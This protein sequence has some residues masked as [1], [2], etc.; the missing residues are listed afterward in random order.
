[1]PGTP[2]LLGS[3]VSYMENLGEG[4]QIFWPLHSRPMKNKDKMIPW[5]WSQGFIPEIEGILRTE[6][7]RA[8]YIQDSSKPCVPKMFEKLPGC[9][10]LDT[11][12]EFT[13][14]TIHSLNSK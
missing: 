10:I 8:S 6:V 11:G 1:M 12:L 5:S 7:F 9:N 2:Y 14:R 13:S 4:L 3:T